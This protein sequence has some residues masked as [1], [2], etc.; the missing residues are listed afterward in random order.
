VLD[1]IAAIKPAYRTFAEWLAT[2]PAE[3]DGV[4]A[5]L[6]DETIQIEPLIRALRKN[7]IPCTRETV[8]AYRGTV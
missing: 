8:R 5:A 7:G 3:A 2:S 6:S 1:D 4:L